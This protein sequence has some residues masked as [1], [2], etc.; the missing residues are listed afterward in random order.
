MRRN[1]R[2]RPGDLVQVKT[3][4]EILAT[5]DEAGTLNRLPFMS[6]MI[7]FCGKQFRVSSRV[8]K[9]CFTGPGS[10]P[11]SFED[12]DVVL[13]EDLRCSGTAHDGCQKS[14]AIFWREAWLRKIDH[15]SPQSEISSDSKKRLQSRLKVSVGPKT[16][17]CQASELLNATYRISRFQRYW[18]CFT[19]IR[20]GNCSAAEMAKR[21][22]VFAVWKFRRRLRGEFAR[23]NKRTTPV[24]S[25]SL[26]PG[27]SVEVKSLASIIETLDERAS[28]RGLSF[29]PGM[30]GICETQCTVKRRIDRIIVDGT[31][32]MRE[33]RNTVQLEGSLC[34]C[35]YQAVGGCSRREINYWREIWLRRRDDIGETQR[36]NA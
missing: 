34:G 9:T 27:E 13:L 16:Y 19:D 15:V 22:A 23:G 17:F 4:D 6:E 36:L 32:E 35:A 12:D 28:N 31:G 20:E 5:L 7:E 29:S 25:L 10:A 11:R 1:G 8:V 30:R 2:M 18:M 14:C 24:S 21:I 3:P 26:K 33:L